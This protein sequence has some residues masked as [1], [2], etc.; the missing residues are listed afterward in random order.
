[1]VGVFGSGDPEHGCRELAFEVGRRVARAGA[2]LLTGGGRGVM[3][4]ASRGFAAERREAREAHR[5]V[6]GLALGILPGSAEGGPPSGYPNPWLDLVIRT[7]LDGAGGPESPSSR[8]WINVLTADRVLVLPGRAG[9]AAEL[10][11]LMK[12]GKAVL[13]VLPAESNEEE[14]GSGS[15]F[16][17]ALRE[18]AP[19]SVTIASPGDTLDAGW[20]RVEAFL[21]ESTAS[22]HS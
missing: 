21:A 15:P 4:D 14:D 3:E 1:M 18:L 11:M 17:T 7:H 20:E 6:P 13:V 10:R 8:N 2:H 19:E 16:R 22:L 9:T 12:Q 5:L